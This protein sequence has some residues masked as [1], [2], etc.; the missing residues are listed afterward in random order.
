M[1]TLVFFFL[2]MSQFSKENMALI[3]KSQVYKANSPW[4]KLPSLRTWVAC[5]DGSVG[6]ESTCNAETRRCGLDPWVKTIPWR[7]ARQPTPVFLPEKFHGQRSL[8]GYSPKCRKELDTTKQLNIACNV[9]ST[10]HVNLSSWKAHS[11]KMQLRWEWGQGDGSE[12]IWVPIM[13]IDVSTLHL[14]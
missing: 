4:G 13:S 8:V 5:T 1:F 2:A 12:Q 10:S 9:M 11:F 6:K 7:R 14:G 3:S